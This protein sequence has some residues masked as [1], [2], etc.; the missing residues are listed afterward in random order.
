MSDLLQNGASWLASQLASSAAQTVTYSRAAQ[1]VTLSAWLGVTNLEIDEG[2]GIVEQFQSRDFIVRT[3]DLAL[4][5][6]PVEPK[7]ADRITATI[8]GRVRTFEVNAPA[9]MDCWRAWDRH[10]QAYRIHT[11]EVAP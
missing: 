3:A 5:G 2:S 9:G 7:R 6:I 1:V 10:G 8:D 11:K 4:G